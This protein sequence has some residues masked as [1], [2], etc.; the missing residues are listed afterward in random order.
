MSWSKAGLLGRMESSRVL[1]T[2]MVQCYLWQLE[3]WQGG[4]L[5]WTVWGGGR[6]TGGGRE[7]GV[8][9]VRGWYVAAR[10][11]FKGVRKDSEWEQVEG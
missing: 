11:R 7:D 10:N 9:A 4:G 5:L 6:G 8:S 3:A 1:V 2:L